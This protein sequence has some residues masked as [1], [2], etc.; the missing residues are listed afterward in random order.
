[1]PAAVLGATPEARAVGI[2]DTGLPAAPGDAGSR[3]IAALSRSAP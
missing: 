1:M 2:D 3:D